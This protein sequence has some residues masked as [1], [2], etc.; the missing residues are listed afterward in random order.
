MATCCPTPTPFAKKHSKPEKYSFINYEKKKNPAYSS[1]ER[2]STL[3]VFVVNWSVSEFMT[4]KNTSGRKKGKSIMVV[5]KVTVTV[6]LIP[7]LL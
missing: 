4:E 1:P 3:L 6:T 7:F 5:Y 2:L